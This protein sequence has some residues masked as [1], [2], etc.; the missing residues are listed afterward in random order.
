[1]STESEEVVWLPVREA[2]GAVD[3]Q[4]MLML[5]PTYCTCLELYD[6]RTPA[7]VLAAASDRDLVPVEPRAVL[8]A[9]G[10]YLSIPEHLVRLGEDIAARMRR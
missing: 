6:F 3:E 4:R 5:P 8:D 9:D 2:I 1:V 10:A 7:D